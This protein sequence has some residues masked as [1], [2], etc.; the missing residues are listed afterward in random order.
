MTPPR[1]HHAVTLAGAVLLVAGCAVDDMPD[2]GGGAPSG[3]AAG[4]STLSR[5][6]PTPS[7]RGQPDVETATLTPGGDGAYDVEVTISSAYDSPERYADGWR[8]LTDDG[9][10]LGTHELAHHHA[11]EQPFTRT[12]TGLQIPPDVR[13]VVVEGRDSR[14]GWG[15]TTVRVPV[16]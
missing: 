2:S 10:V 15:G 3:V 14:N 13:E 7:P 8:V 6:A 9:Q 1:P 16:P 4:T 12:Q 11:D 5:H